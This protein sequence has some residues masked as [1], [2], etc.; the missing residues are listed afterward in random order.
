MTAH[1]ESFQGVALPHHRARKICMYHIVLHKI[2]RGLY[3][4]SYCTFSVHFY[5][6]RLRIDWIDRIIDNISFNEHISSIPF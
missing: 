4:V 3:I 5:P 2:L 6:G 1:T